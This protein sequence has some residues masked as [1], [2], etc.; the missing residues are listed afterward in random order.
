MMKITI[1]HVFPPIPTRAFDYSA[2]TDNYEPGSPI[3]FG[4]T[5]DEARA[6]LLDQLAED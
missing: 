5:P 2:V 3:G 1:T 4:P 6:D